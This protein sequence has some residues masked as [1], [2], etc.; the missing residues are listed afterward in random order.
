[1]KLYGYAITAPYDGKP[2][3]VSFTQEVEYDSGIY[4]NA[5]DK[6]FYSPWDNRFFKDAIGKVQK[7]IYGT[8]I[9]HLVYLLEDDKAK[10]MSLL[11]QSIQEEIDNLHEQV[12]LKNEVLGVVCGSF[13]NMYVKFY[14]RII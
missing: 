13:L 5:E 10:A 9:T 2:H 14:R 11:K 6:T 12:N 7:N 1:M 3:K 4:R 8:V